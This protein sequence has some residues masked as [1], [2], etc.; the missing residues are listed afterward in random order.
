[1]KRKQNYE[2]FE[3][4]GQSNF[5]S[6][7]WDMFDSKAWGELSAHDI[8]LYIYFKRKHHRHVLKGIV[9]GS[10]K[11]NIT[12]PKKTYG[13]KPDELG[14]E[15]IMSQKTFANSIDH[16]I[17]FG[18]V[19]VVQHRWNVRLST[20]YGFNDMWKQYGTNKFKVLNKDRRVT[21]IITEEHK[22]AISDGVKRANLK[23]KIKV[24]KI[25]KH[26]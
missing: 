25:R 15:D 6:I 11:D 17:N 4:G 16:L 18:F 2:S 24:F 9:Y 3:T 23:R 26:V 1:M 12:F 14:Y 10:N 20:I 22:R 5:I 8:K 13:D 19:R 21:G 7:Y